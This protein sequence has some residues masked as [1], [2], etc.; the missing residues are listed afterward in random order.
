M[1]SPPQWP[2]LIRTLCSAMSGY[3]MQLVKIL[4]E[5][6]AQLEKAWRHLYWDEGDEASICILFFGIPYVRQCLMGA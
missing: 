5:I 2:S 3:I 6:T 1:D 4:V